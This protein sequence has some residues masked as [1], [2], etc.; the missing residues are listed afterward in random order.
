VEP[1]SVHDITAARA[2][3]LPALYPAAAGGL[4][5]LADPGYG[6]AATGILI[7]VK[8]PHSGRELDINTRTRSA[9]LRSL[10]CLGERWFALLTGGSPAAGAPCSTSPPA[11][12]KSAT[13][14]APHSSSPIL[15][16]ATSHEFR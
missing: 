11:P 4:P 1:D 9:L 15:N 10:R 3:A 16:A 12:A 5:T 7:S 8:Q 13:S 14:S 6:G 2:H